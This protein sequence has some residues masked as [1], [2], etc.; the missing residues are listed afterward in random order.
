MK[1]NVESSEQLMQVVLN[2][3]LFDKL[4]QQ[5]QK[6]FVL[7]NIPLKIPELLEYIEFVALIKEKLY[8]L[9]MDH[10]AEYLNLMYIIDVPESEFQNIEITDTVDVADQVT[11]LIL[12]REYKKVWYRNRYQ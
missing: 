11:F 4:I 1:L 12:K 6:D 2:D 3:S 5:V 10:F 8:F 7:A 9:M